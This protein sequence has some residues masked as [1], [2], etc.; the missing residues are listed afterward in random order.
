MTRTSALHGGGTAAELAPG[1]DEPA[2]VCPALT[3]L[4]QRFRTAACR[5]RCHATPRRNRRAAR[6]LAVRSRLAAQRKI[7]RRTS[8]SRS[9]RAVYFPDSRR[10]ASCLTPWTRRGGTRR[11]RTPPGSGGDIVL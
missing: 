9:G 6:L 3:R 8:R 5:L 10:C 7:V 11:H 2:Y 1:A 4:V